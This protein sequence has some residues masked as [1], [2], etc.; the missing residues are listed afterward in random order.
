MA[1]IN[2]MLTNMIVSIFK[3]YQFAISPLLGNRC[4]FYPSCSQYAIQAIQSHGILLGSYFVV[5]RILRCNP[6]CIG[7]YDP[8]PE[9]KQKC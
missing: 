9:R 2:R 4:R 3:M 5:L 7:G 6:L 8:I 1:K